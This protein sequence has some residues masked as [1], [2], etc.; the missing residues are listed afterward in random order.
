MMKRWNGRTGMFAV[1]L[2]GGVMWLAACG[3]A[4]QP[5]EEA[6]Q[7]TEEEI[8]AATLMAPTVRPAVSVNE[9]MVALIDHAAHEIWNSPVTPPETE[10]EWTI[11]EYH[12]IQLSG[13]ATL[14]SLGGSGEAD[15]G[16]ARLP[17]WAEYSQAMQDAG[18]AALAAAQRRDVDA[19]S[20]IADNLTPTC[21]GCHAEVKPDLPTEGVIHMPPVLNH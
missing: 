7:P 9:L 12:A 17:A 4:P 16:W 13:A 14:I 18:M 10:R 11:L 3:P 1:C 2:A 19:L 8:L 5:Q 6:Q 21:E 15:P 20:S